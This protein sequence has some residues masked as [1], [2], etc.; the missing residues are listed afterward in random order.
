MALNRASTFRQTPRVFIVERY[1]QS[2]SYLKCQGDLRIFFPKS[3]VPE[4]STVFRSVPLFCETGSVSDRKSS[5]CPTALD[6][7]SEK[8]IRNSL[9]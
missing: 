4:K 9:V 6:G 1:L 3:P 2:Q 5:G 8:N 7:E